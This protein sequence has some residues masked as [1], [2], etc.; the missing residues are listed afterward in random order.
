MFYIQ[1]QM[2]SDESRSML[3]EE[4]FAIKWKEC[5]VFLTFYPTY[6]KNWGDGNEVFI[7]IE[8]AIHIRAFWISNMWIEVRQIFAA[9]KIWSNIYFKYKNLIYRMVNESIND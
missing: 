1:P 3:C 2:L 4:L 6:K 5:N 9:Y 7:S 8:L